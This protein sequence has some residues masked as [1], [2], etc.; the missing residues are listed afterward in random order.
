MSDVAG[1]DY[2]EQLAFEVTRHPE[3][4]GVLVPLFIVLWQAHHSALRPYLT[5]W[6]T[7]NTDVIHIG[8]PQHGAE[9]IF[10]AGGVAVDTHPAQ[11]HIGAAC[12]QLLECSHVVGNLV[13]ADV[14]MRRGPILHDYEWEL[15]GP[16]AWDP[17]SGKTERESA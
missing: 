12:P 10:T 17:L 4:G 11:I 9:R 15:S 6:G 8:G 13:T 16:E 5:G 14:P 2:Q 3:V 7:C 1:A